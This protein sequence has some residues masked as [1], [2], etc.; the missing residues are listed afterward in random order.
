M[1]EKS[2]TISESSRPSRNGTD[3]TEA[4]ASRE[5]AVVVQLL[6]SGSM[7]FSTEISA[8]NQCLYDSRCIDGAEM[9]K[10]SIVQLVRVHISKSIIGSH[11]KPSSPSDIISD[12][13]VRRKLRDW[14][15]RVLQTMV[16][17]AVVHAGKVVAIV[18]A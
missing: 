14:I 15:E 11:L 18:V 16:H 17:G 4:E 9:S 7:S 5:G 12:L 1:A 6:L 8:R 2:P 10:C 13:P 3:G